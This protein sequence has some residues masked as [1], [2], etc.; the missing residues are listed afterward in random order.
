MND[1][2]GWCQSRGVTEPQREPRRSVMNDY[3][4]FEKEW[5]KNNHFRFAIAKILYFSERRGRRSLRV[6]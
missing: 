2:T 3:R 6:E 4:L 5:L 1:T